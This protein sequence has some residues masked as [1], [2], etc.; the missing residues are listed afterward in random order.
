MEIENYRYIV[1]F[2]LLP[3]MGILLA[4]YIKWRINKCRLFAE[5]QFHDRLFGK[6]RRLDRWFPYVYL[7]ALGFL[8]LSILGIVGKSHEVESERRMINTIFLLDVSNSMNAEDVSTT[9]LENAKSIIAGILKGVKEVRVGVVVFAGEAHSIVPLTTDISAVE[10]YVQALESSVIKAQGTDFLAAMK[11]A[12]EKFK[13]FPQNSRTAVLISD[14][15]DHEGQTEAIKLAEKEGI[16]VVSIGVGTEE[17]AP[18]PEY[19]YGRLMDYKRDIYGETVISKRQE[20]SLKNISLATGGIYI[21]G[22]D[23]E[24]SVNQTLDYLSKPHGGTL[25]VIKS[26]FVTHY[27]QY[28]LALALGLFFFIYIFR[29]DDF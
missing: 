26:Q 9:R 14:G 7:S 8:L 19:Y 4:R 18:I 16:S 12:V 22:N 17:G 23:A 13:T 28:P 11:V 15:E 21:D 24:K 2:V 27:Y 3:L 5:E 20:T 1:L 10:T 6:K 29:L 25:A